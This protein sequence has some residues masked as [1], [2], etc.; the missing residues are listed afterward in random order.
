MNSLCCCGHLKRS[1][2]EFF[3]AEELTMLA[4]P[5][6]VGCNVG[7][8][9]CEAFQAPELPAEPTPPNDP[10]LRLANDT[11]RELIQRLAAA[12]GFTLLANWDSFPTGATREV[13]M[14][15]M[16]IAAHVH[17]LAHLI[18]GAT[19]KATD[20]QRGELLSLCDAM[21]REVFPHT[22]AKVQEQTDRPQTIAPAASRVLV[23]APKLVM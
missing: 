10:R 23:P 17:A 14:S 20:A 11:Q 13:K 21:L 1:H 15:E 9:A 4:L 18:A 2:R 7:E 6:G 12:I 5:A 8:C 16:F 22:L 19:D 3:S